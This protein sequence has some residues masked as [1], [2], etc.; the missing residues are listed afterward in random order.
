MTGPTWN[1]KRGPVDDPTVIELGALYAVGGA[2]N[3]ATGRECR[4]PA[5]DRAEPRSPIPR[6]RVRRQ[7]ACRHHR[8]GP[9]DPARGVVPHERG[10]RGSTA[11]ARGLLDGGRAA[12]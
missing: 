9:R 4:A 1:S 5:H 12:R 10:S 11:G 2:R 7:R 8:G 6:A 3:N